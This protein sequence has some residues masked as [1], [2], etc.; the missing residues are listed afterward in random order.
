MESAAPEIRVMHLSSITLLLLAIAALFAT[1]LSG[2]ATLLFLARVAGGIAFT[3]A[4]TLFA[5]LASRSRRAAG[6]KGPSSP[7]ASVNAARGES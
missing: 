7:S 1:R 5:A 4:L 6:P 3:A 2:D